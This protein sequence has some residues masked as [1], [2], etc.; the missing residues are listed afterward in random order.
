MLSVDESK[1]KD[2]INKDYE[3][4]KSFFTNSTEYKNAGVFGKV[5]INQKLDDDV[6]EYVQNSLSFQKNTN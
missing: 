3:G 6:D 5:E 1:L 2:A 4:F